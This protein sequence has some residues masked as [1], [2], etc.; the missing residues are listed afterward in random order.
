MKY[1]TNQMTRKC[2]QLCNEMTITMKVFSDCFLVEISE[3][4]LGEIFANEKFHW[5]FF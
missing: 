3:I 5:D 2:K 4:L 1:T